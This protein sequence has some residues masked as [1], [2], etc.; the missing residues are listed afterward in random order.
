MSNLTLLSKIVEKSVSKRVNEFLTKHNLLPK[1]QSAYRPFH[2]T[3]SALLRVFNDI[4]HY[5][6]DKKTVLLIL[7]DLSAA[8]D[9]IDHEIMLNRLNNTFKFTGCVLNWFRS[10]LSDRSQ[11]VIIE[12]KNKSV[13]EPLKYGVPQGSVLGPL[14]FSMYTKPLEKIITSF[15]I[16]HHFYA[17][18][19]QLYTPM[20]AVDER[21]V[22][23]RTES[24][25]ASI[26]SWMTDN[27]L[28][29]NDDKTEILKINK[30]NRSN[31]ITIM[32][33]KVDTTELDI[34]DKHIRN[35]GAFL[36]N[37]LSM[38]EH[39]TKI[40][41]ACNLHLRNI[42]KIRSFLDTDITKMLVTSFILSR[43][44]YCNSLLIGVPKKLTTK[45]QKIQNKAARVV[46]KDK[47]DTHVTPI[48][49]NLHW[50]P[51][52]SRIKFKVL[53]FVYKCFNGLSPP[54]LSELVSLYQPSRTLRSSNARLMTVPVNKPSKFRNKAFSIAAPALWNA[55]SLKTKNSPHFNA[56]KKNLKTE[57]FHEAFS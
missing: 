24:C 50:L 53:C 13:Q 51:V 28:K 41:Q 18:D 16:D 2:S 22:V 15:S 47:Y 54:Y 29:L 11:V 21:D 19:T 57:L 23:K 26:K 4:V 31:D 36:D 39:V 17:D 55:V 34:S 35:L 25:V 52:E 9:T 7:L 49:Y 20:C 12:K 42:S 3:E 10:Y 27:K 30:K 5:M 6:D 14:L 1:F 33:F 38:Q 46:T 40:I 48:L 44:D 37:E 56:F 45:L 8:F 32:K 43:L